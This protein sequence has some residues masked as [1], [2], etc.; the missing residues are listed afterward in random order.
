MT[1]A[2]A[3]LVLEDNRLQTLALSIAESGGAGDLPAYVRLIE[4]FEASG[5][6]DRVVEGLAANDELLRR[7][8]KA[9]A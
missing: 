5:K 1:D 3:D 7:A 4:T 2:V 6:L 9:R 8:P